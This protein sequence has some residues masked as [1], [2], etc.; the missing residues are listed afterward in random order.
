[1]ASVNKVIIVGNLGRDPETRY[2]PNG[3][4]V[5]NV[6]VATT[7]SW[8]DKNSGDKKEVT[9]WHR[10]TFYRKL[11]EIA[12]QYLKKGS[13]VYIEGRLQTRK[14]T[15]KDGVERYTTEIIAD[16]MQMLGGRPGAG[17]GSAS[18]DDDYGS[19]APAPRQSSGGGS[20]AARPAAKPAASNFN[21]M[22]DDIPF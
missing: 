8:K 9:E 4:A 10:I 6:A 21:D 3:E 18:M 16:T 5:T 2:M 20:S 19:S 11:A 13:S 22:D 14:W 17:G 7:E 12:G 15:D 1:M